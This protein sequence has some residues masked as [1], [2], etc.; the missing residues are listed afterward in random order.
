MQAHEKKAYK[1]VFLR[2]QVSNSVVWP[3]FQGDFLSLREC[4]SNS[5][6]EKVSLYFFGHKKQFKTYVSE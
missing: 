3:S 6:R 2:F 4:L 1:S 5:R